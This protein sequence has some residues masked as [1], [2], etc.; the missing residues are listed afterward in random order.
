MITEAKNKEVSTK[1]KAE[2]AA[3]KEAA[4]RRKRILKTRYG[5]GAKSKHFGS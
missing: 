2:I 1:K 4:A 3:A 5:I